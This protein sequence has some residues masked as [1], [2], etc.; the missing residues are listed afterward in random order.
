MSVFCE[1]APINPIADYVFG[2]FALLILSLLVGLG[3]WVLN[4]LVK[5]NEACVA[6]ISRNTVA[7]ENTVDVM[8]D[9]KETVKGCQK[10]QRDNQTAQAELIAKILER[11]QPDA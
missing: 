7:F 1:A 9:L 10:A 4:K 3:R 2:A 8:R 6:V 11:V 5:T